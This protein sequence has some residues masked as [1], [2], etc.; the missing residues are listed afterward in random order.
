M[1]AAKTFSPHLIILDWCL[2]DGHGPDIAAELR[3]DPELC[4]VPI[5]FLTG[6]VTRAEAAHPKSSGGFPVLCKPISN[7]DL[8][9]SALRLAA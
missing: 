4:D 5:V 7:E 1:A 6:S 2:R 3:A 9:E 8:V